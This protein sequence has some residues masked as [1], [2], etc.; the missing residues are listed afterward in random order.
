MWRSTI[1]RS[2]AIFV[3]GLLGGVAVWRG[4]PS[5]P[6]AMWREIAWPFG[7]DAWPPGLAFRCIA[8]QCG[9]GAEVYVRPKM[10]F[11]NCTLGVSDDEEVDRVTD[12]DLISPSFHPVAAGKPV[13]I[14]GLAGRSR[15]YV[16][17]MPDGTA[18][19]AA[20]IAL[21]RQCDAVV[22]VTHG[23]SANAAGLERAALDLLS[24]KAVTARIDSALGLASAR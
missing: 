5:S 2:A 6:N 22:A 15:S 13:Q 17:D 11:C 18:R 21:S 10:G 3:L 12:L 9:E 16:L 8:Q 20:G 1:F 19:A 4:L 14:A 23:K 24:S 7:R